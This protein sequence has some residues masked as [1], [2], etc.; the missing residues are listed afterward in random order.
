MLRPLWFRWELL[1]T[2]LL[3]L[4]SPASSRANPKVNLSYVPALPE[5]GRRDWTTGQFPSIGNH[6]K[7]QWLVS[8]NGP[9]LSSQQWESKCAQPAQLLNCGD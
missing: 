7:R 6:K 9:H 8:P 3:C 1:E 5:M 4:C 2:L